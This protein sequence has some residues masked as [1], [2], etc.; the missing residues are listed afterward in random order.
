MKTLDMHKAD[1]KRAQKL[2]KATFEFN[3]AD[4][5]YLKAI[6]KYQKALKENLRTA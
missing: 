5:A 3:K 6:V 1:I 2:Y 4:K